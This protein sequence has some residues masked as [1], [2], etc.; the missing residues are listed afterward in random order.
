MTMKL[1]F[2]LKNGSLQFLNRMLILGAV[3]WTILVCGM[4]AWHLLDSERHI[5]HLAH[6]SASESIQKDVLYRLWAA[7]HGGVYV[8]VTKKTPPNPYLKKMKERDIA[9]PSGRKLT[10]INPAYMTRQ[11]HEMVKSRGGVTGH[12]TSLRPI[13]PENRADE[14]EEKA[15]VAIEGGRREFGEIVMMDGASHYRLMVPLFVQEPCLKCHAFQGYKPGDLRGG[16]SAAVRMKDFDDISRAHL[17]SELR[18]L[19]GVWLLGVAG[20][21]LARPYVRKRI[22]DRERA[23]VRLEASEQRMRSI[24]ENAP[25]GAHLFRLEHDGRLIFTGA[26]ASADRILSI[27]NSRFIGMNIEEAFPLLA[28]THIPDLYRRIAATGKQVEFEQL[29]LNSHEISGVFDVHAFQTAP[30]HVAVFFRDITERKKAENELRKSEERFRTIVDTSLEGILTIDGQ[31][32]ITFTNA[33]MVEMLGY[34]REELLGRPIADFIHEDERPDHEN[35]IELRR[36]GLAAEYDRRFHRKDGTVIWTRASA[37][38]LF[39]EQG[40]YSGTFGLYAD[41]T[42]RKRAEEHLRL[43]VESGG[44]GLWE[45]DVATGRLEWN[46][47]LK[48]IFGLAPET[49]DLTLEQFMEAVHPEEVKDTEE[50]FRRALMEK[51]EFRHEY[52][53]VRPDQ[54]VHWIEAIGRGVYDNSGKPVRM[55][56]GAL[57]ITER[58][59]AETILRDNEEQLRVI[60][61]ASQA[62]IILVGPQGMILYANQRMADMFRCTLSELIGSAYLD[63]LHPSETSSADESMRQLIKGEVQSVSSERNYI[64]KDGSDFWGYL[65]GRRLENPDGSLRALVGIIADTTE[66][67]QAETA[68]RESEE[69]FRLLLN[70]TGEAIYGIDGAGTCTF[71]NPTC[72]RMLGYKSGDELLGRNMHEVMHHTRKD[73]TPYPLH[74]CRVV[75]TVEHGT[76]AHVSDEVFW[77]K[78]GKSFPVE[79]W[80]YPQMRDGRIVGAV[81]TFVDITDR[82]QVEDR[83]RQSQKMEAV[84]TLA[85]GIA[86]DFNNIMMAIMGY[87]HLLKMG[88]ATEQQSVMAV[89]EIISS[90]ERAAQLTQGLLAFSRKQVMR[91]SALDLNEVIRSFRNMI[92]RLLREDIELNLQLARDS[93]MIDADR[94][95]V[96]QVLMNLFTNARDAM[97]KGGRIFITTGVS[98][99]HPA[100]T[101][102]YY[103]PK[104]GPYGSIT[105]SDTGQGMDKDTLGHIFEPFFTTKEV[106]KGTGLGLSMVYGIMKKHDGSVVVSSEPGQG[107]SVSLYL[108]LARAKP[109]VLTERSEQG[110]LTGSELILV[111]EDDDAVR[112]VVRNILGRH[113]YGIVEAADGISAAAIFREKEQ[114]IRLV[115]SDLVMPNKSGWE[116]FQELKSVRPDV[117]VLFLSGYDRSMLPDQEAGIEEIHFLQKPLKPRDLLVKVRE[118][119]D[120]AR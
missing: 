88:P 117:K 86:H 35:Q 37:S 89:D 94:G 71:C 93:I 110:R 119:L 97:P 107:T 56:G 113:G 39:D 68:L 8:P 12:L 90:A 25:F 106:G 32:V 40:A 54:S 52:R 15:L 64:R 3:V 17:A 53:I 74:E 83:L 36:Q 92:V 28:R 60:F 96:E 78:D 6:E 44:V 33:R 27:D 34:S 66:R 99:I 5:E 16:I 24:V 57:D 79:Y 23:V 55:S 19:A 105:V 69:Q 82:I 76:G 67:K 80:S 77:R 43:A 45:W 108:P 116:L 51:R 85:G 11:V 112:R 29:D 41:V 81:V 115:I 103:V 70:S 95:Q 98:E 20:M 9:T 2:K 31:E 61:E 101:G 22:E 26:N 73:G 42:E 1:S 62:G 30:N 118:M 7:E 48:A 84:G 38:P 4:L 75:G 58:K 59:R 87:A 13:R 63:H 102:R 65:S 109:V 49:A 18:H 10:L 100:E 21:L 47:R 46:D 91:R 14:W 72:V 111:A 120:A 104:P 50:R 114:D